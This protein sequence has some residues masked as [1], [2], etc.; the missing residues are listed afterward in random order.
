M[1]GFSS[2]SIFR[3]G[4]A[5]WLTAC[6]GSLPPVTPAQEEAARRRWPA[7]TARDLNDGRRLYV[8]R[9]S[10]CHNLVVP[11]RHPRAEW[12]WDFERMAA[13][14][15]LNPAEREKIVRYLVTTVETGI[16]QT[17]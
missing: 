2:R 15:K 10:G 9:C 1:P 7:V 12:L 4:V 16:P 11:S 5:A 13:K 6:A 3:S 14:A 8:A 17:P